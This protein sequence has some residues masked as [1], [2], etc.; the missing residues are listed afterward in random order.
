MWGYH[1]LFHLTTPLSGPFICWGWSR[2][3]L[4][5]GGTLIYTAYIIIYIYIHIYSI[6][7]HTC[8]RTQFVTLHAAHA[9]TDA[10]LELSAPY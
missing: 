7:T 8:A 1:V 9:L 2:S 4:E 6:Y 10:V 5:V 3:A